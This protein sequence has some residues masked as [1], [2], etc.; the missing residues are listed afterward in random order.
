[1]DTSRSQ[2]TFD[3]GDR[4]EVMN[5]HRKMQE[6][7]M[8]RSAVVIFCYLVNGAIL[9]AVCINLYH[10]Q[11]YVQKIIQKSVQ[12]QHVDEVNERK[13]FLKAPQD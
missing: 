6:T 3:Y 4:L 2:R 7:K 8:L 11:K 13:L 5:L 10:G 1:M 9:S 12:L